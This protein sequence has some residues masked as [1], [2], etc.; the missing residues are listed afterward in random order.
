MMDCTILGDSIAAGI[1]YYRP[2]CQKIVMSGI[3]S[4][5]FYERYKH[6]LNV[7]SRVVIISLGTNDLKNADTLFSLV[8]LRQSIKGKIVYWI[9]PT[10]LPIKKDVVRIVAYMFGDTVISI[11]RDMMS[12]DR[13]HPTPQGYKYL[14]QKKI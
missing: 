7:N 9:E 14:D 6:R 11:P 13:I 1:S 2:E 10:N 8:F 4:P 3:S 5:S 12:K